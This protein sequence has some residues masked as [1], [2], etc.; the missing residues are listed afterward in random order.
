VALRIG[1]RFGSSERRKMWLFGEEED[2][3]LRRGGRLCFFFGD[4]KLFNIFESRLR[5]DNLLRE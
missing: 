5:H 1:G 2:V 4:I 3:T